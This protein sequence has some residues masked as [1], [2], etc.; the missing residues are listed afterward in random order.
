MMMR[1]RAREP[2]LQRCRKADWTPYAVLAAF[3]GLFCLFYLVAIAG[4]I[5]DGLFTGMMLVLVDVFFVFGCFHLFY[6]SGS[7]D[8]VE[9]EGSA[10]LRAGAGLTAP[11]VS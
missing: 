1:G 4:D 9:M 3:P 8:S 2:Y 6:G 5:A 11:R 7:L 10:R